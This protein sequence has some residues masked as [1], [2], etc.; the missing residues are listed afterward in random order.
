MAGIHA[1]IEPCKERM[2][3]TH[4][5]K[6]EKRGERHTKEQRHNHKE[7]CYICVWLIHT[8]TNIHTDTHRA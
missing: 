3:E 7:K 2:L 8:H 1:E 5:C 4:K 6:K